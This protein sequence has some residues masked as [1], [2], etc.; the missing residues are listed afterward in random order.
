V[1]RN[2]GAYDQALICENGH[3]ATSMLRLAPEDDAAFCE[4]CGARN[5]KQCPNCE[6]PIRGHYVGGAIGF[7]YVRPSFCIYCGKPFPWTEKTLSAAKELA[8]EIEELSADDRERLKQNL[9]EIASDNPRTEVAAG[10][11]RNTIARI[12]PATGRVLERL[13]TEI[14]TEAARKI[15]LGGP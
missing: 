11:I 9:E 1:P 7:P 4:H 12:G 8:D 2:P 6:R 5:L 14:A 3:V 15:L 10:R 13:A